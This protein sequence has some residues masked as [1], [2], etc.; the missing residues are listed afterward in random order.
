MQ[1]AQQVGLQRHY[2]L[3]RLQLEH[4]IRNIQDELSEK[5]YKEFLG[6]LRSWNIDTD[7]KILTGSKQS[8]ASN[9]SRAPRSGLRS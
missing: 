1:V 4:L 7:C 5:R 3:N 8:A 6:V 2:H 9:A